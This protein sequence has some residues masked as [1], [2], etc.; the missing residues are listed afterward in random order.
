MGPEA[1]FRDWL[2]FLVNSCPSEKKHTRKEKAWSLSNPNFWSFSWGPWPLVRTHQPK[3]SVH[4]LKS[5]VVSWD[6]DSRGWQSSLNV[7]PQLG[8]ALRDF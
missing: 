7:R 1:K 8:L 5:S 2:R 3:V 6:L 4:S